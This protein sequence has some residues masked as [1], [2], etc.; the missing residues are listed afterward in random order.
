MRI[1]DWSSDVCSSDLVGGHRLG[2][3]DRD[4]RFRAGQ[5]LSAVEVATVSHDLEA[6]GVEYGLCLFVHPG[7]L[8]TVA[9]DVDDIMGDDE[10]MPRVDHCLHVVAHHAGTWWPSNES[11]D[12]SGKPVGPVP[13]AS[14]HPEL[15][16]DSSSRAAGSSCSSVPATVPEIGRAHV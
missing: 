12:R 8:G 11:Q 13:L 16:S 3:G 10:M 5:D 7:K 4:V 15:P 9:A 14:G 1:S 2:Q 6:F